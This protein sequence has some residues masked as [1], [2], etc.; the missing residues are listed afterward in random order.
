M[1]AHA[2]ISAVKT[3]ASCKQVMA[4]GDAAVREKPME[5]WREGGMICRWNEKQYTTSKSSLCITPGKNS[6]VFY[7]PLLLFFF[8]YHRKSFPQCSV[9]TLSYRPYSHVLNPKS[10]V[11]SQC[12]HTATPERDLRGSTACSKKVLEISSLHNQFH[13]PEILCFVQCCFSQTFVHLR[14][15]S[16]SIVA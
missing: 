8:V 7:F 1:P 5:T 13:S 4:D 9:Q 15:Y 3:P 2:H 11:T 10:D 16:N 14:L 12:K 6:S